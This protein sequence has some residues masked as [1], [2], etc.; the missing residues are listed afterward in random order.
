MFQPKEDCAILAQ[1]GWLE[2]DRSWE[3]NKKSLESCAMSVSCPWARS[4]PGR[5]STAGNSSPLLVL[6]F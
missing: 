5:A 4:S 2:T 6:K 3:L 1:D